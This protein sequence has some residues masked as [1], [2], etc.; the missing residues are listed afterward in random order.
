MDK[1]SSFLPKQ[2]KAQIVWDIVLPFC[3]RSQSLRSSDKKQCRGFKFPVCKPTG[4]ESTVSMVMF[5]HV[6]EAS[7]LINDQHVKIWNDREHRWE[8]K[9][10]EEF[11]SFSLVKVLPWRSPPTEGVQDSLTSLLDSFLVHLYVL[12]G[13]F[14]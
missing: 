14:K 6:L 9:I 8:E 3:V 1:E 7:L 2:K 12:I 10:F 13:M 5:H 11:L 4:A